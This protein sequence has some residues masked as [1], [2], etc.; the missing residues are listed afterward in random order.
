MKINV[1]SKTKDE[2]EI[3]I[4]DEE[5]TILP[6]LRQK[7]IEDDMVIHAN[8]TIMHPILDNPRL[9]VK[10]S[11]GKP[12]N[13]LKRA[14]KALENDYSSLRDEFLQQLKSVDS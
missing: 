4:L 5:E 12:Q 1:L 3:E 10:V 13:A 8:Y 11:D 7:L 14:A 9:Y 6:P 2:I